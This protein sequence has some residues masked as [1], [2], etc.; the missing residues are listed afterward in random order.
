MAQV[1]S[2]VPA[3]E[4][5]RVQERQRGA[6]RVVNE[7]FLGTKNEISN[8]RTDGCAD[9]V[10]HDQYKQGKSTYEITRSQKQLRSGR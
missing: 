7:S 1:L 4:V 10:I 2:I 3:N 9:P 5:P 6:G 8:P